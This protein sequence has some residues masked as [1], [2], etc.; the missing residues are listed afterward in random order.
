MLSDCM[1]D[2]RASIEETP[3]TVGVCEQ[4]GNEIIEGETYY[5][6][7]DDVVCDDCLI[8]YCHQHYRN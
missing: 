2:Y 1:Y 5:I 6:F 4:C 3:S 8:E 7:I